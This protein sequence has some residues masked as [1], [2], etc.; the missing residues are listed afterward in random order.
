L[1]FAVAY[2]DFRIDAERSPASGRF[3]LTRFG[4]GATITPWDKH[5]DQLAL[6]AGRISPYRYPLA[7]TANARFV[8]WIVNAPTLPQE[9]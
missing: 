2:S 4:T 9:S 5:G 7:G 8:A 6:I 1:N 3:E